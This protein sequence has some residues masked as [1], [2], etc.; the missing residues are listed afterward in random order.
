MGTK[1]AELTIELT[2]VRSSRELHGR[3]M[4]ALQFPDFHGQNWD[5][6]WDSV[7]GLV[8]MSRHLRLRGWH[9]LER[10]LPREAEALRQSLSRAQALY[11][12]SAATVTYE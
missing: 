1:E 2:G 9:D 8:E 11:P 4:T 12:S 3:L 6:F 7:T 5:A 10:L